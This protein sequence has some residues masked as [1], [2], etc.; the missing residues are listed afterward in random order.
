M[1]QTATMFKTCLLIT[2]FIYMR[3]GNN[4]MNKTGI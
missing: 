4:W 3:S 2:A 1:S